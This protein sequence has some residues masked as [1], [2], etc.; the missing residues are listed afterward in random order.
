MEIRTNFKQANKIKELIKKE[1]ANYI[2]GECILLDTN[3]PQ[4]GCIYSVL[5]KYFINS[6]LPLDKDLY[7]EL[8]PDAEETSGLY[9]KVCKYCNKQ[10]TSDKKNEQYCPKCKDKVK[11]EKT[12][13]RV[14]K[15]R[16][17]CNAF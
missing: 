13:L 4:M 6:V 3:C 7:K 11:K 5:C 9:N 12:K 2:N 17:K 8:L 14:Q 1:C 16:N 15:H 10:F